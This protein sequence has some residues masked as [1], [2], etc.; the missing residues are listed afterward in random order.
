MTFVPV[1][2]RSISPESPRK[3]MKDKRRAQLID[4][5]ME[6]IAR[7][8]LTE[9]T[10]SHISETA[11]MSRGIINF[12]F[13][14]KEHM[15]RETL[16]HLMQEQGQA[17]REALEKSEGKSPYARLEDSLKSVFSARLWTRKKLAVWA[18]F[19]AHAATH[20]TY[21]YIFETETGSMRDEIAAL[22]GMSDPLLDAPGFAN[23]LICY[24][25]GLRMEMLIGDTGRTRQDLEKEALAFLGN[26]QPLSS[27]QLAERRA[28][29]P[30]S[31]S[32][33]DAATQDLFA[34]AS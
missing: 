17:W 30:K 11:G 24:V 8:G 21:R 15:M 31:V 7:Y 3:K 20:P 27:A 13:T 34:I 26:I 1:N 14:S 16:T 9:T 18:A 33:L 28:S 4:A 32:E 5:N 22:A 19:V 29:K 23:G 10:I 25:R 2:R 6:C 12:Y